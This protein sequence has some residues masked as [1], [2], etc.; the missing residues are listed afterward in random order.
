M[1]VLLRHYKEREETHDAVEMLC[2]I[3]V[4]F[5]VTCCRTPIGCLFQSAFILS[6]CLYAFMNIYV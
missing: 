3:S 1:P 6:A 4:C 2:S 5:I